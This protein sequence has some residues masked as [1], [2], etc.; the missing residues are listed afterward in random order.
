MSAE[1]RGLSISC[2]AGNNY[3]SR[4]HRFDA[5]WATPKK[6]ATAPPMV[7]TFST[8]ARKYPPTGMVETI[9]RLQIIFNGPFDVKQYCKVKLVNTSGRGI[10]WTFKPTN[11]K[12]VTVTPES[13]VLGPNESIL[14]VVGCEAFRVGKDVRS[15]VLIFEWV[16]TPDD[17]A[18]TFRRV[19]LSQGDGRRKNLVIKYNI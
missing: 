4:L 6:R 18:S 17:A 15:D 13:G 11:I 19:W 14:I 3:S 2:V 12:R 10:G 1:R 5:V 7:S 16:S 8:V 9:P